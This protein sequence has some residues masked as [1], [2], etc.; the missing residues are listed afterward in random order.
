[1]KAVVLLYHYLCWNFENNEVIL[2]AK[3]RKIFIIALVFLLSICTAVSVLAT[4]P[5]Q[6][7]KNQPKVPQNTYEKLLDEKGFIY[8]VNLPWFKTSDTRSSTFGS[9][10]V[11]GQEAAYTHEWA[12]EA[13]T[14]IK[15]I[16]FDS[17]RTWVFT[18]WGGTTMDEN[19]NITGLSSEF[20]PNVLDYMGIVKSVGLTANLVLVPHQ[21]QSSDDTNMTMTT[22]LSEEATDKFINNALNP[23]LE[24]LKPYEEYIVGFD[25]YC[26]PE[27][28][29]QE[30]AGG[31]YGTTMDVLKKFI[32]SE[33]VAI[34]AKM[35]N[36]P[37]MISAGQNR[38]T[39]F[40]NDV[41]LDIL[42]LDEYNDK[43]EAETIKSLNTVHDVWMTECGAKD[44][45]NLSDEFNNKNILNFYENTKAQGYKA[46]FAWH[47]AGG[48]G[49]S[50]TKNIDCSQLRIS[51]QSL[52]FV[53]L[54]EEYDREG[55][56]KDNTADKP[57]FLKN[58]D[59]TVLR[60]IG[61]R[62]AEFYKLEWRFGKNG[63][64]KVLADNLDAGEIGAGAYLCDYPLPD[65]DKTGNYQFKVT[66]TTYYDTQ[67]T[68]DVFEC[69]LKGLST[70][71]CSDDKNLFINGGFETQTDIFTSTSG[72]RTNAT[73]TTAWNIESGAVR[74]GKNALH[75]KGDC[76]RKSIY[77]QINVKPNTDYTFTFFAKASG[78]ELS[79]RCVFSLLPEN[80]GGEPIV[81]QSEFNYTDG[82]K[83]YSYDFNSGDQTSVN[84]Q[85]WIGYGDYYLDD[86]YLF[87]KTK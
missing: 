4:K 41:D 12:L 6:Q 81:A 63:E 32:N 29:T 67:A 66:A 38:S 34:R 23:L 58:T 61:T 52:H 14:N 37:I 10:P 85:I 79:P 2:L 44:D 53:I 36:I 45:K 75:L 22:I 60:W 17:V 49:H 31:T 26:E 87:E 1:M 35:P 46:C 27:A 71:I 48:V 7:T 56:D 13:L 77:Q 80:W 82:W 39:E 28:D 68:S 42:G 65:L 5:I 18:G 73:V 57:I 15:A 47:Y 84:F 76:C 83:M 11:T 8:G 64:W 25:A 55:I 78:K 86:F 40:Y 20:I 16:G 70:A 50:F 19:G 54:D 21:W 9:N 59:A 43:G 51:A 62:D 3:N 74:S 69:Y 24:A 30:K 72:W 33:I